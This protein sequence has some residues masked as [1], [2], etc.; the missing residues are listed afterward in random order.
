LIAIRFFSHCIFP[1]ARE[2]KDKMNHKERRESKKKSSQNSVA[3]KPSNSAS[4]VSAARDLF[5]NPNHSS[6]YLHATAT[7]SSIAVAAVR[8]KVDNMVIHK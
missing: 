1:V 2:L 5:V 3:I 6:N 7:I 8:R 4:V